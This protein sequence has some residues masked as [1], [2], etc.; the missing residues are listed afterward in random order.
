MDIVLLMWMP[1]ANLPQSMTNLPY[2]GSLQVA[3]IVMA[4][5]CLTH[6]HTV[7]TTFL[8]QSLKLKESA[9]QSGFDLIL[10]RSAKVLV[11]RSFCS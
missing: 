10:G 11:M 2:H 9:S 8:R 7:A 3:S 5:H 4:F 1:R 6:V